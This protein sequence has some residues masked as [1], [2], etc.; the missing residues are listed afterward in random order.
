MPDSLSAVCAAVY[1]HGLC[2]D[3][4]VEVNNIDSMSS[5]DILD[6]Y[7][8]PEQTNLKFKE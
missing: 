8:R 7:G 5:S 1:I 6:Y 2:A 4:Y 3:I